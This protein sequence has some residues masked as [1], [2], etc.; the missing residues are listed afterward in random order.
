MITSGG[1]WHAIF[2]TKRPP[3]NQV[4]TTAVIASAMERHL[5]SVI[6]KISPLYAHLFNTVLMD[7]VSS[8]NLFSLTVTC[9]G[10][11]L[12]SLHEMIQQRQ[13]SSAMM[14]LLD[15]LCAMV[16][17]SSSIHCRPQT[18]SLKHL[19]ILSRRH[20]PLLLD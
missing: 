16:A 3:M 10:I 13:H 12:R 20:L 14:T 15:W 5:G 2:A 9:A 7:A 18:R 17:T 6:F 19:R 4:D 11:N 8:D 1:T